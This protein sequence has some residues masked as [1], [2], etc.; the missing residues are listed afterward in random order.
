MTDLVKCFLLNPTDQERVELRRF[1]W[2]TLQ[3]DPCPGRLGYHNAS[4]VTVESQPATDGASGDNWSHDD[5]NWPTQCES[6]EYLFA[7]EDEW[8]ANIVPLYTRS[9]TGEVT[10]IRNS[11]DGAMWFADW[12]TG[13]EP[14]GRWTGPDGRCLVVRCPGGGDW[15]IDSIAS[16][17]TLRDDDTHRCWM[18]HGTPPEITVNKQPVAPFTHTCDA[19]GG[20]IGTANYHGFLTNGSFTKNDKAP[21]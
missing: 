11:G 15:M 5:P 14:G 13:P 19:G 9:D 12:M 21:E 4:E 20:S 8:Q 2:S 1:V 7:N 3:P 17:C 10:T 6:C 18:R 16:N